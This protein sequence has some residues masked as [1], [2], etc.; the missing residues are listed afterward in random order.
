MCVLCIVYVRGI[1]GMWSAWCE[2]YVVCVYCICWGWGEECGVRYVGSIRLGMALGIRYMWSPS[3][4]ALYKDHVF[5][6]SL[7]NPYMTYK[8]GKPHVSIT[9]WALT[10]QWYFNTLTLYLQSEL[11]SP[12]TASWHWCVYWYRRIWGGRTFF[13]SF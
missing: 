5:L 10:T 13:L 1:C 11:Q 4:K 3:A 6:N 7:A 9:Y 8:H 12:W 2:V